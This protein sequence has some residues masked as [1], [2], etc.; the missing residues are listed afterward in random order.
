VAP[1]VEKGA[2]LSLRIPKRPEA[3][4]A[5]RRALTSLNGDLHLVSSE[6]LQDVQ[7][8]AT[9]LVANA[10]RHSECDDVTMIVPLYRR[11]LDG[12]RRPWCPQWWRL[13]EVVSCLEALWRA[14]QASAARSRDWHPGLVRDHTT[15]T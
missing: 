7:L 3:A 12:T 9:E 5:A 8:M 13:A 10:I 1:T 4:S 2:L 14:W 6:R 15:T 11:A